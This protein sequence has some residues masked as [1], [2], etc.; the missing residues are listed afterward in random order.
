M[1]TRL[2]TY[3]VLLVCSIVL[4]VT[5]TTPLFA[6]TYDGKSPEATSAEIAFANCALSCSEESRFECLEKCQESS[7]IS[8]E[9][10]DNVM[11]MGIG[12]SLTEEE[13]KGELGTS[14]NFVCPFG[15]PGCCC[16]GFLDCQRMEGMIKGCKV[17]SC[18]K[19]KN[20]REIC[21]CKI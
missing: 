20:G 12:G 15:Y 5:F 14:T 19:D 21:T 16:S 9:S 18:S 17:N 3:P 13:C 10:I 8:P 2:I 1:A 11:Y 4:I 7:G 6:Q